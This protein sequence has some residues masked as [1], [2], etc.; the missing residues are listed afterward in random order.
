MTD[1]GRQTS[2]F[3]RACQTSY[4]PFLKPLDGRSQVFTPPAC[5]LPSR[6]GRRLEVLRSRGWSE[7]AEASMLPILRKRSFMPWRSAARSRFTPFQERPR[8]GE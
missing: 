3:V 1:V 6:W 2:A 8:A 7:C 4:R 5:P